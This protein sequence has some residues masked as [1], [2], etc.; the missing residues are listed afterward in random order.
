MLLKQDEKLYVCNRE[1]W[2]RIIQNLENFNNFL[3]KRVEI[4][5]LPNNFKKNLM[6]L[7]KN[8]TKEYLI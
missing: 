3:L 2:R 8:L 5:K 6:R 4:E 1:N 7:R